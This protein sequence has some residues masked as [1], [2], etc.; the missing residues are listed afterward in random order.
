MAQPV[1]APRVNN[2][3]D[4]VKVARICVQVGDAVAPGD[5][6]LEVETEKA[7]VE[8]AAETGGYVLAIACAAGQDIAIGAIVLWLGAAPDAAVPQADAGPAAGAMETGGDMTAKA[9]LL[10]RR[11]ALSAE[12]IPRA[13]AR[14]TAADVE[15]YLALHSPARPSAPVSRS[16]AVE[17]PAPAETRPLSPS[18]RGMLA[19]VIWQ[20]DHAAS[21][22]LELEYDPRPWAEAA[23]AF[24]RERRLLFSPLLSLMAHRLAQLA[25]EAGANGTVLEGDPAAL[26]RYKQANLGFTVQAGDVLYLCVVPAA[27][28]LAPADFVHKLQDLQRRAMSHR[29]SPAEM[30]GATVGF[31]SMA[32]WGIRRHQPVLAPHTGVMIAHTAAASN[33]ESAVLGMT[34]DHR[35]LSGLHAVR[36]LK[37]LIHPGNF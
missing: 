29:L 33:G 18:A 35:L 1:H 5:V 15:A 31:T 21:A 8:V 12:A 16:P 36:L 2:N 19:T 3:D 6:L 26:V 13:A 34:Y 10:L 7:T 4:T 30:R 11:H 37:G 23:G 17:L 14:L 32:R 25:P 28:T 22:Y 27:D 20:R 9:R 24:M